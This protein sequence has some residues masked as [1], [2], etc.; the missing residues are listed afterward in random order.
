[1]PL[2]GL[3]VD[4]RKVCFLCLLLMIIMMSCTPNGSTMPM[5][6]ISPSPPA[7]LMPSATVTITASKTPQ[8]TEESYAMSSKASPNG[9]Y[10]ASAIFYYGTEQQTIE[11]Q[12]KQ[13]NLL[14]QIPYQGELPHGDPRTTIGIYGWS[15]DS[16]QLYFCYYWSPDGGDIFIRN[17][18]NSLQTIDVKTGELQDVIPG[19]YTAF[20]ISPNGSQIAYLECNE[21][22]IIHVRNLK[23]GSEKTAS[24]VSVPQD[25]VA[26]GDISWSPSGNGLIF[27]TQ[28]SDYIMMQTIY[29]NIATMKVKVIK[30]YAVLLSQDKWASND[31]WVDDNTVR[32]L[33][34]GDS[35]L[36]VIYLDVRSNESV[37]IGTPTPNN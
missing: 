33:E 32:F 34:T 19:G 2:G 10:T 37:V 9:E 28:S 23:S 4:L 25:Y 1:M 18:C 8:P 15:D 29:V 31:G 5:V 14:W 21:S 17:S 16:S 11:I 3:E 27:E 24:A 22:C 26:I 20:A 7:T 6:I 36:E 12:D 35:E 13:G 30:K